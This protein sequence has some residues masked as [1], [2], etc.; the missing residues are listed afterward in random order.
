MDTQDC[1]SNNTLSKPPRPPSNL[2]LAII[3]TLLCCLPGGIVSI[4][5]AAGV[6]SSYN[7]G[8]YEDAKR[9]SESAKKWAIASIVIGILIYVFYF[10]AMG[11]A[12]S[13]RM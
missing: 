2:A 6:D 11:V 10:G 1:Y 8:D 5:Y 12:A 7:D 9:K 3:V 4:V 13:A